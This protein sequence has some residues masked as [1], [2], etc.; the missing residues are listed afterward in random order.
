MMRRHRRRGH[1][2]G[3]PAIPSTEYWKALEA[4]RAASAQP[5]HAETTSWQAAPGPAG[6]D[7]TLSEPPR[8]SPGGTDHRPERGLP[9]ALVDHIVSF[10]V[11]HPT[12]GP[13]RIASTLALPQFGAWNVSHSAVYTVLRKKGLA[14][15]SDRLIAAEALYAAAR[16]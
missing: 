6:G 15:R 16:T 5:V 1:L 8:P 14:R 11:K 9:K 7:R 13:R 12:A 4:L 2:I 10:A 3:E